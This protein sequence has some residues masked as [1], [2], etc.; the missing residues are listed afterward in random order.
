MRPRVP[1]AVPEGLL[2]ALT[3][4]GPLAFGGVE[5]WSRA[6]LELSAFLMA[7]ACFL[8]GRPAVGAAGSAGWLFPAAVALLGAAQTLAPICA[9][10]PRPAGP[11]TVCPHAT[12]QAVLLW[13]AYAAVLYSVPRIIVTHR[14]ARRYAWSL[15][16]LGLLVAALGAAQAATSQD[17]IYWVRRTMPD[18]PP[19]GPYYNRDHAANLLLMSLAIGSGILLSRS[20]RWAAALPGELRR[21][22]LLAVGLLALF[23][24]IALSHSRAALL[25]M[26]LAGCALALAGADFAPGARRRRAL[27]AAALSTLALVVFFAF[28]HVASGSAVG[29]PMDRSVLGRLLIYS[30]CWPRWLDSPWFG[31]GLGSFAA[32]NGAYQD[33]ALRGFVSHAHS[34]WLEFALETGAS[35]AA[36]ALAAAAT[37]AAAGWRV[38]RRAKSREMRAL[39]GGALAAAAAFAAHC[40][41]EFNFQIPANAVIFFGLIGFLLSAPAWAD[42]QDKVPPCDPPD[43]AHGAA[44][45][46]ACLLLAWLAAAPAAAAWYAG[47]SGTPARRIGQLAGAMRL[48]DDPVFMRGLARAAY[49]L[50]GEGPRSDVLMLRTALAY[51][52]AA[53]ADRPFDAQAV[54]QAASC[55]WRLGRSD[56]AEDLLEAGRRVSFEPYDAGQ[57]LSPDPDQKHVETLRRLNLI[58]DGWPRR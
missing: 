36:L 54:A 10:A 1:A 17:L 39:I 35:G 26:P 5:P 15:F 52:L 27:I 11:F 22:C 57:P 51:A 37:A 9:D 34:D 56:D 20:R 40:L 46:A 19:F 14:A 13:S 45:V 47:G 29:A 21:E 31:T 8:R 33:Q 28:A 44:A 55:L 4:F 7:L 32:L 38:W 25:A 50:A 53:A 23:C 12:G 16:L 18:T 24:A 41:F 42:K 49:D 48:D 6:A 43:P 58:P 3:F 2:Y 30:A